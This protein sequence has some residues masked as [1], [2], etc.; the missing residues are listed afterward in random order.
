LG[1][2]YL[3]RV[4]AEAATGRGKVRPGRLAP[5]ALVILGAGGDLTNRLAVAALYHYVQA[6][7]LRTSLPP[8]VSITMAGR[9]CNGASA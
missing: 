6:G 2:E 4:A 3:A 1:D 7:R 9:P 8:L 5:P